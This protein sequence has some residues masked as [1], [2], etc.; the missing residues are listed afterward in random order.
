MLYSEA[1]QKQVSITRWGAAW[2]DKSEARELS[3]VE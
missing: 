2:P 3:V 1:E